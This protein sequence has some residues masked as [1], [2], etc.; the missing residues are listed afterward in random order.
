MY[1]AIVTTPLWHNLLSV[2][3]YMLKGKGKGSPHL[4]TERRVPELI[5]VLCSQPAGDVSQNPA[6]GC[7]Y[8]PTGPQLP[9]QPLRGLLPISLLGE[10][11]H[12]GCKQTVTRQC[13]GCDLNPGP[14]EPES[15]TLTSR[16]PSH[17]LLY[18]RLQKMPCGSTMWTRRN[19]HIS[20]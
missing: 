12:D 11:R 10:H 7:H 13:R 20:C 17:H 14:S 4:I 18:A 16:L 1:I 2:N 15:N 19:C 3:S 6:V 9:S 5:P 8:F